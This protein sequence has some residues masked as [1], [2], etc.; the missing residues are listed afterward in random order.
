M[1]L[2]ELYRIHKFNTDKDNPCHAFRG[3]TYLD[4]YENLFCKMR[5]QEF[6][7]IE[8]GVLYGGSLRMW[9]EYFPNAKVVGVDVNPEAMDH[10]PE[11]ASFVLASQTDEQAIKAALSSFPPLGIV[12]DDG[13]HYVPHMI[14]SFRFL[15][16][17]VADGGVYVMEDTAVSYCGVDPTWPGMA[18]NRETFGPNRREDLDALLLRLI[19]TMDEL[20]GDVRAVEFHPMMIS[21]R[22]SRSWVSPV[23]SV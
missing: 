7:L 1:T 6:T 20:K 14:E 17:M 15:W 9:M 4:V 8:L 3:M 23:V 5:D 22:K 2:P 18:C 12:I 21:L 11:G 13:S 10:V 19:R 16:P